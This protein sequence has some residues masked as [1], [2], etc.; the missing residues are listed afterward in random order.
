MSLSEFLYAWNLFFLTNILHFSNRQIS[1]LFQQIKDG[2]SPSFTFI[3]DLSVYKFYAS[4]F[5]LLNRYNDNTSPKVYHHIEDT[6]DRL[7]CLRRYNPRITGIRRRLHNEHIASFLPHGSPSIFHLPELHLNPNR[8]SFRKDWSRI[9][10]TE[11]RHFSPLRH[12]FRIP[13]T[14]YHLNK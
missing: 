12:T 1:C 13:S 14:D 5:T 3:L 2:G 8:H 7:I 11:Y 6:E 9:R 10:Y 4:R